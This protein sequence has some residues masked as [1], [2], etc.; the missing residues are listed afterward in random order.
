MTEASGPG[1]GRRT[2]GPGAAAGPGA[3][4]LADG[5]PASLAA[6]WGLRERPGKGPKPGL[7]LEKIVAAAVH[8]GATDG[9]A[10]VSMGR[11][12]AELGAGTMALYRYVGSKS[13]LLNLMVDAAFGPPPPLPVSAQGWRA[14]LSHWA[15]AEL[16]AMRASL[17]AVPMPISGPP[18]TPNQVA[19][20]EQ[21]LTCMRDTGLTEGQ[22]M[23]VI[24]LVSGYARNQAMLEAQLGEA[25]RTAG[26]TDQ[27]MMLDYNRILGT[28]IDPH[29]FP[30]LTAVVKSGV[31]SKADD[32]DEEFTFGLERILD[33]IGKLV[34]SLT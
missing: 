10:A 17:W 14:A 18:A 30:E 9:L 3:T 23:S 29:R 7:S 31:M 34:D 13:E 4:G 22:K 24:L 33:G 20:M 15:W 6:V 25:I 8:V 11:V 21:G 26:I 1:P 12:A 19:W 28:V 27:Q 32:P 2:A 16:A 5:L